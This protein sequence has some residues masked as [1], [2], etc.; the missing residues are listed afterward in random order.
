MYQDL[1]ILSGRDPIGDT[2]LNNFTAYDVS[3]IYNNDLK[4]DSDKAIRS[5]GNIIF[6]I[7]FWLRELEGYFNCPT[8]SMRIDKISYD[9][10][11]DNL[12]ILIPFYK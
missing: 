8:W 12:I 5:D 9:I 4:I 2:T 3:Y 10:E 11:K 6:T 1:N 7:I